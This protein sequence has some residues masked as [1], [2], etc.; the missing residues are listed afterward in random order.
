MKRRRDMPYGPERYHAYL[1]SPE[2]GRLKRTVRLRAG[3]VC[4]NCCHSDA[5]ETHHLTYARLYHEDLDDLIAVCH[6]CHM[7]LSGASEEK[8]EVAVNRD[9]GAVE[10][11]R[12]GVTL[13][14][15]VGRNERGEW[16]CESCAI[17][18]DDERTGRWSRDT[19]HHA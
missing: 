10:C 13:R 3:G 4:E 6:Q 16:F 12:C 9:P 15:P 7:C 19:P 14:D 8:W 17:A 5:T 1:A 18:A 11:E 2:W